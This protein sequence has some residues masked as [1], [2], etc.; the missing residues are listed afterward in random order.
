M[1]LQGKVV[2]VTGGGHGIGRALCERFHREGARGIVAA[3]ID[4]AAARDVG[5]AT[6]GVGMR[7]DVANEADI[8]RVVETATKQYGGID[9]F[10]S[11]AGIFYRDGDGDDGGGRAASLANDNWQRI[12]NVNVVPVGIAPPDTVF[13]ISI[14]TGW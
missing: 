11:N 14:F 7:C 10:C 8:V 12:W 3:D 5:A 6:G 9:M 4:E 13:V 2:V 1:E